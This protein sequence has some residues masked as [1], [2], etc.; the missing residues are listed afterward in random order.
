MRAPEIPF[1]ARPGEAV[2]LA[3]LGQSVEY[4]QCLDFYFRK[5]SAD[6]FTDPIRAAVWRGLVDLAES[7]APVDIASV[8]DKAFTHLPATVSRQKLCDVIWDAVFMRISGPANSAYFADLT[9]RRSRVRRLKKAALD[10]AKINTEDPRVITEQAE[11]ALQETGTQDPARPQPVLEVL[12][13]RFRYYEQVQD[14]T[15]K[16]RRTTTGLRVL[17]DFT[18]GGFAPGE[19]WIL[20]AR[21]SMG[22]TALSL[23]FALRAAQAGANILYFS[24]E[25]SKESIADRI[26]GMHARAQAKALARGIISENQWPGLLRAINA[27]D[28]ASFEMVSRGGI[29]IGEIISAS[30]RAAIRKS[31]DIILVDYLGNVQPFK[32]KKYQSREQEIADVSRELKALALELDC[33]TVV[34]AQLNREIERRGNAMPKMS[35]LRESGQIEAD[36]DLI[37]FLHRQY[38][39]DPENADPKEA[40]LHIAKQR[41]GD[42]GPIMLSFDGPSMLFGD[43]IGGS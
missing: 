15:L 29:T 30:R 41:N 21:P 22:K 5:I 17:D 35:D 39:V 31:L 11:A 28:E 19:Q 37:M 7:A 6:D 20:A 4:P 42:I 32:G 25:M 34:L 8:T 16:L 27:L 18:G 26:F 9:T 10:L 40:I 23:L 33:T 3:I 12:G 43:A 38:V 1:D 14:G 24:I 2:E 13:D 36:A